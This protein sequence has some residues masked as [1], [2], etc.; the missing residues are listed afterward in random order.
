MEGSGVRSFE[1]ADYVVF[2]LMLSVSAGIGIFYAF[3]GGRQKTTKEFLMADRSM[4]IVPV[5]ISILVSFMSAILILGTP[6]EMYN[7]GT[8]YILYTFGIC[9]AIV[10]STVLF[11]P[12]LFNL[13]L[14]SSFEYLEKRFQSRAAKLIGTSLMIIQQIVYMGIATFSPSTA[15]EAVTGFP[16]WATIITVGLVSTFYT[17]LGGM[18]AVVWTDVFQSLVMLAGLLAI[19]IE[20]SMIIGGMDQVWRINDEWGRIHFWNFS[21]DPTQRHSFWSL[22]I[23]GAVGWTATYG[24]NQASVQRYCALPTLK[25]A[26]IS[27]MLNIFGVILLVLVVCLAGI[28]MFAYYAMKGCDPLSAGYIANSNQLLP[29]FVMEILG[30]PGLPGLFISCLFSGAL[31]TMSSCLNALAAVTWEDFLKTSLD[32]RLTESQKTLLT[33]FL[34]LVFGGAGIAMSFVAMNLGGT[35][36]QASLSFTGAASGPILG[37]FALGA[38]FPWANWIGACV[39]GVLGLVFPMWIVIGSYSVVGPPSSMRF[40]T[41]NCTAPNITTTLMTTLVTMTTTET[42][43]VEEISGISLLY[44]VSYLWLPSIGAATVVVVGLIVSFITGPMKVGDVD[45]KYMVPF[46]D[47]LF[48]CLPERVSRVLRC[49]QEFEDPE[50]SNVKEDEFIITPGGDVTSNGTTGEPAVLFQ[51]ADP[52]LPV[53]GMSIKFINPDYTKNTYSSEYL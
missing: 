20:G 21:V 28:I 51:K 30:Y 41:D 42:P 2:A 16:V 46:F 37:I 26:K 22:I 14:T 33:K 25:K 32:D 52:S 23:G 50:T 15:L 24:V 9:L 11:V 44:T 49:N 7:N 19:L 36:L 27:V 18:K 31:S 48:C 34:V 35:V 4:Q 39:G 47:R 3:W 38:F 43:P 45:S 53:S 1:T 13:K 40:P 12:L 10:L 5:A 8:E 6:A 29:F 17:S